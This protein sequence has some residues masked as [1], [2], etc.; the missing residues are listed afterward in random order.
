MRNEKAIDSLYK[1]FSEKG[2]LCFNGFESSWIRE[3]TKVIGFS[4][5]KMKVIKALVEFVD[6]EMAKGSWREDIIESLIWE[7]EKTEAR[8]ILYNN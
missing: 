3:I 8:T 5:T 1:F 2:K 6:P 4:H 7:K